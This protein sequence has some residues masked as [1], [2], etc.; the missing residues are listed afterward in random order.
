MTKAS[1]QLDCCGQPMAL[2]KASL[3]AGVVAVMMVMM[4]TTD[5]DTTRRL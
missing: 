3:G 1:R 4:M 2:A 5:D